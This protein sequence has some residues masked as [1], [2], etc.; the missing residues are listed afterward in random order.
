MSSAK[1]DAANAI[2]STAAAIVAPRNTFRMSNI[3]PPLVSS[4]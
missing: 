4:D 3:A 2:M 1:D